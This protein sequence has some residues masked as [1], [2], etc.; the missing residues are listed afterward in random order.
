MMNKFWARLVVGR[1]TFGELGGLPIR[2]MSAAMRARAQIKVELSERDKPLVRQFNIIQVRILHDLLKAKYEKLNREKGIPQ[3]RIDETWPDIWN[4]EVLDMTFDGQ[5]FR[6]AGDV[7]KFGVTYAMSALLR[8]AY[9]APVLGN[10]FWIVIVILIYLYANQRLELLTGIQ[11]G[12]ALAFIFTAFWYM[13]V[14]H[15]LSI[16]PLT[17]KGLK[18]PELTQKEFAD[19]IKAI[20]G[21]EIRPK[22]VRVKPKF[23]GIVRNYQL[24]IFFGS[25]LSDIILLLLLLGIVFGLMLLIDREYAR[26]LSSYHAVIAYGVL[27]AGSGIVLSFY[28]FAVVLQNFRKISAALIAALLSAGLPFLID[29]LLS[30]QIDIAGARVAIFA[31]SGGLS[32]ALVTAITSHV[33]E[34]IE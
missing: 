31:G 5:S 8:S 28:V 16:V 21:T 34:S 22:N 10:L 18:L 14:L 27:I 11:V 7:N 32:V 3:D 6:E 29:Y 13:F 15:N 30:G 9:V 25:V 33:K 26:S 4:H 20:E 19:D 1:P 2:T 17:F 12:I 24:R 23:Y